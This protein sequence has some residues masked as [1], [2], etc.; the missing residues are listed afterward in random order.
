VLAPAI[1]AT[2]AQQPPGSATTTGAWPATPPCRCAPTAPRRTPARA[3]DHGRRQQHRQVRPRRRP[4]C[5]RKSGTHY[6]ASRRRTITRHR[7]TAN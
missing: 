3:T 1:S 4:R 6:K 2:K 7:S 5:R